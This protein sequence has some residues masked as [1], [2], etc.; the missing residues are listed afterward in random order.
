MARTVYVPQP[1][2]PGQRLAD[3][4]E[5][6]AFLSLPGVSVTYNEVAAGTTLADATPLRTAITQLATVAAATGVA[7]ASL[8]PG[9]SQVIYHNGASTLTVYA[10]SGYLVDGAASVS[11]SAAA[12]C[13]Y[14]CIAP[15][16]II[17]ALL[18]AVSA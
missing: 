4:N 11:L 17:S 18:G 8:T 6:N 3:N 7:L 9:K 16:V 10:P 12:R 14:T 2:V 1:F 5:L 15:G 13:V